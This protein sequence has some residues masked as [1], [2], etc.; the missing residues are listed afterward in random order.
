[1]HPRRSLLLALWDGEEAGLLGSRYWIAHPTLPLDQVP[2]VVNMD[3][4]GRL[5]KERLEIYGTRTAPGLRRMLSEETDGVERAA[6]FSLGDQ[7]R[8]RS[9]SVHRARDSGP[10][11]LHGP[12]CRLPSPE[13][14][15]RQDQLGRNA[16]SDATGAALVLD[17]AD[18]D[19][20]SCF[21]KNWH[22]EGPAAKTALEQTRPA[23]PGR[24]GVGWDEA[25][26]TRSG[27][28]G[29]R[30][31]TVEPNSP[32]EHRG[33]ALGDRIMSSPAKRSTPR[34]IYEPRS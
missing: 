12:A 5:R 3:M 24:L 4:I 34:R 8:Q 17:L 26:N 30:L 11:F 18:A 29:L 14:H 7:G 1:M 32:A 16:R 20:G 27:L 28:D 6:G 2:I 23:T 15:G 22:D 10:A 13:R 31:T 9:F 33:L 25:D 19:K 21:R